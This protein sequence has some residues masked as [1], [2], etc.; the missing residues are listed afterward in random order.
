MA[1]HRGLAEETGMGEG[2][3]HDDADC[4]VTGRDPGGGGDAVHD[5]HLDVEEG[6]VDVVVFSSTEQGYVLV[7]AEE[8]IPARSHGADGGVHGGRRT[9]L[10]RRGEYGAREGPC[11][12][13]DDGE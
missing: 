9:D 12:H 11:S 2:G 8:P 13:E 6:H 5:G 3:E 10:G 4:G 7:G 1:A